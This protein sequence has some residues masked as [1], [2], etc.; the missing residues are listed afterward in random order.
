LLATAKTRAIMAARRNAS[1]AGK[2][3]IS[4]VLTGLFLQGW[5]LGLERAGVTEPMKEKHTVEFPSQSDDRMLT[6]DDANLLWHINEVWFA[7]RF[8]ST[9]LERSLRFH[10]YRSFPLI[11]VRFDPS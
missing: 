4:I 11:E 5:I 8:I 3:R 1:T 2:T 6:L 10:P 9:R 7:T